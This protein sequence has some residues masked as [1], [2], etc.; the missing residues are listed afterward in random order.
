MVVSVQLVIIKNYKSNEMK[1]VFLVLLIL[2]VLIPAVTGQTKSL[3]KS[4]VLQEASPE[5]A[6][7]SPE[8]L[9][10]IDRCVKMQ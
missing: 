7:I 6:G 9:A 10:R 1:K 2:T 4:P 3:S 5:E 8:R